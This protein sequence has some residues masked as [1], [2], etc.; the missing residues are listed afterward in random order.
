M[1]GMRGESP[2]RQGLP[3]KNFW[4]KVFPF[5]QWWDLVGWKTVEADL[6]A[7]L[8]AAVVGLPQGMAFAM[9]AGLP[10][11]YGIYSGIVVCLI[12]ALFGSSWHMISGPAMAV[13][14][15][16]FSSISPMAKPGSAEFIRLTLTLTFLAG[17]FQLALGLAR[18]G[19]LVNFISHS[20]MV[21]FIAGAS[22]LIATSQLTHVLGLTL[23]GGRSFLSTWIHMVQEIHLLNYHAV[24]VACGTLACAIL[25]RIF[26]PHWP[27][28][29]LAIT[30]GSFIS[31]ILGAESHGMRLMGPL[32]GHLPPF[33]APDLSMGA[34]QR[35]TPKAV[36][37]A[38][39]G[40]IQALS[41]ARALA[42]F[43]R[44]QIDGNQEFIGQGLS[45]MVGSFFSGYAGSG[46]FTRSFI[47]Y[48]AGAATPLSAVF[49]G[50][51]LALILVLA[52]PLTAYLPIP[53]MGGVV[54]LVAFDLIDFPHI[55][56][57]I[58]TSK[59]EAVVMLTT[60]LATLFLE[61]EFAI[62]VGVLLSFI[63]YIRR[64]SHPKIV[65][66]M[67]DPEASGHFFTPKETQCSVFKIIRID[68]SLFF[69]AVNHIMEFFQ[70]IDKYRSRKCHVLIVAY[71][72]N[73]IDITGAEMLANE[74]L[75]RR[76]FGGD[77]FVLGLNQRAREVLE[78]G[79]YIEC[80]GAD[81]IFSSETEALAN[82]LARIDSPEC[83]YCQAP[84]FNEC[85]KKLA[86]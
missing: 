56:T 39:L 86:T 22:I 64:T 10:P 27:G 79:G 8:T 59:E 72:I 68:G 60:F 54:L 62:Y 26:K 5:L 52:A 11:E 84:L 14:I 77:L 71:G 4:G 42:A 37:V 46:S 33:S 58:K 15:V 38:M 65:N 81:H 66:L 74:S 70:N 30:I 47:N 48:N 28:L 76:S 32:P 21:G 73:F 78:R 12:A 45:N 17:G 7:G 51:S 3:L 40:L 80:I 83:L 41:I 34:V 44:Q 50:M 61:L 25:L 18:M 24:A 16:V 6:T 69:G 49:C 67:P 1:R 13:S 20:V 23:R 31:L 36:A 55:R 57:I 75:R 82:I 19:I 43:S 2:D 53:A 35:L 63:F 85:R 29:L 9:I